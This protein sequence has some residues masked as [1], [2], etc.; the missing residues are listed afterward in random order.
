M[1]GR[2]YEELHEFC[3]FTLQEQ[4]EVQYYLFII[5]TMIIDQHHV[6]SM[7]NTILIMIIDQHHPEPDHDLLQATTS[8]GAQPLAPADF[9]PVVKKSVCYI[10]AAVLFNEKNEVTTGFLWKRA[11]AFAGYV[12]LK[13]V[14]EG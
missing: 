4:N 1:E 12:R 3:D 2:P 8:K 9:Q 5:L 13:F 10:V 14:Q 7:I 6:P 11:F